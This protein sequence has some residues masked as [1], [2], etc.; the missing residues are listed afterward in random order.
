MAHYPGD[1][2]ERRRALALEDWFDEELGPHLRLL[3]WH[4][5]TREPERLAEVAPR[6]MMPALARARRAGLALTK[7]FVAL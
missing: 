6:V 3:V 4:E 2:V 7:S 1:E 5:V